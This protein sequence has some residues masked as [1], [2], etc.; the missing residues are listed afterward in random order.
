VKQMPAILLGCFGL[1]C[2]AMATKSV[3]RI[4]PA[5]QNMVGQ[6]SSRGRSYDY[7]QT[8]FDKYGYLVTGLLFVAIAINCG[9]KRK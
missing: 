5:H 2:F 9:A 6:W 3:V 7:T 8:S 1:L 4:N